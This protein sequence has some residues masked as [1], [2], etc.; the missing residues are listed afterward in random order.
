MMNK[1]FTIIII[2]VSISLNAQPPMN[3]YTA[4]LFS[5]Y[6]ETTN[7]LFSSNVPKPQPGGGFYEGLTGYPLNVDEFSTTPVNLNMNIFRPAG[8]TLT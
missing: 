3:R 2:A 6:T 8:D 5:G 4:E 1:I 7:V